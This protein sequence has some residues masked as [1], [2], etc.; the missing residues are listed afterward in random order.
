MNEG[1]Y[2][3]PRPQSETPQEFAWHQEGM[4]YRDWLIGMAMQGILANPNYKG[5]AEIEDVSEFAIKQAD[6]VIEKRYKE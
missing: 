5:F 4:T 3:F 2:A 6:S 1:G